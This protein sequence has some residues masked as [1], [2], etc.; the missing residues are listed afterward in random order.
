M[1]AACL[2]MHSQCRAAPALAGRENVDSWPSVGR[3]KSRFLFALSVEKEGSKC[4]A[5]CCWHQVFLH[6]EVA[7]KPTGVPA[8]RAQQAPRWHR[9]PPPL[10]HGV[11]GAL[12]Q[13]SAR[14]VQQ[15]DIK[16]N[17]RSPYAC[18][19]AGGMS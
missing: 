7:S 2:S 9:C 13:R 6:A 12:K 18:A 4:E 19:A 3:H 17:S 1:C 11:P 16:S 10:P 5:Y 14:E 15:R 8:R